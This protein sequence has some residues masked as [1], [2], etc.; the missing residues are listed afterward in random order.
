MSVAIRTK[1]LSESLV[2][3]SVKSEPAAV[4]ACREVEAPEAAALHREAP[5]L[6]TGRGVEAPD[7]GRGRASYLEH[8][9]TH[10]RS[11]S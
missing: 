9:F 4:A 6:G 3:S 8:R 5:E 10:G 11:Q 7:L 1:R 2:R